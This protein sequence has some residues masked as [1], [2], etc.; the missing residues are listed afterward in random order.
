MK[1]SASLGTSVGVTRGINKGDK[2]LGKLQVKMGEIVCFTAEFRES[3]CRF[4]QT[5]VM[6]KKFW[7]MQFH[8]QNENSQYKSCTTQ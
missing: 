5:S 6:E 4:P 3:L 8:V 1:L 2:D 7:K